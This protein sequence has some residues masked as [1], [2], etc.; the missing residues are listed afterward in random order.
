[1]LLQLETADCAVVVPWSTIVAVIPLT[2]SCAVINVCSIKD[3]LKVLHA[4]VETQLVC[5]HADD[6]TTHGSRGE[7]R[8]AGIHTRSYDLHTQYMLLPSY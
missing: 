6:N 3:I 4:H 5:L 7:A 1:M 2:Y 8:C